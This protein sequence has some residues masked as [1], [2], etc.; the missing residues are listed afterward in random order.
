MTKH[1]PFLDLKKVNERLHREMLAATERVLQSGWYLN[2]Q[3]VRTFEANFAQYV[4]ASHAVG[5]GNG[6]DA[7]TLVLMALKDLNH[8][9]DGDEVIVPALT[10]VATAEAVNRAGLRPVFADV[11][12]NFVLNAREAKKMVTSRTRAI[13]PVHLYGRM[14]PMEA[15]LNLAREANLKVIEDAAQAHGA[16]LGPYRAGSAGHAAAFSFYPG[17]NLGA[18]GD[19]GMVTTN[20][21]ALA[22][23]VRILANYGAKQKYHHDFLGLNSRLDELQAAFLDLRLHLLDAD[24]KRRREIAAYYSS[25]IHNPLFEVPYQGKVSESIFHIYPLQTPQRAEAMNYLKSKGIETLI[26][27]PLTVPQQ[28]AYATSHAARPFPHAEKTATCE[29]SLPMSP[30]LTDEDVAYVVN[31]LN[32]FSPNRCL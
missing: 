15:L 28:K 30:V 32:S 26:H 25:Q 12:D 21:A 22:D 23:R 6:L 29:M 10:F 7:L 9:H 24:N 19:G 4:G 8:W 18:L 16:T 5:V 1:I 11:D 3:E 27:Y 2:G 17:K 13:M 14:A 31:T 20:D